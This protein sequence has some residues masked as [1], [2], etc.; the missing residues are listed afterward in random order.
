[1]AEP[2]LEP[3]L[4]TKTVTELENITNVTVGNIKDISDYQTRN[5]TTQPTN[6][7]FI[8]KKGSYMAG[9]LMANTPG[10]NEKE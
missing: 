5:R 2:E 8:T 7:F 9:V 6:P 10:D 4:K 1:M 3:T